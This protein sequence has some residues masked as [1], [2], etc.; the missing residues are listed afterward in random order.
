MHSRWRLR[1]SEPQQKLWA[2][3]EGCVEHLGI[4]KDTVNRCIESAPLPAH[5][6]GINKRLRQLEPAE[7]DEWLHSGGVRDGEPNE[8]AG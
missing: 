4:A 8:H 6:I 1:T 7:V 3:V 5:T 2:S